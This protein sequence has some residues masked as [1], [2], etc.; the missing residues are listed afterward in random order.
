[1]P[2]PASPD[3]P[4]LY[5]VST[6]AGFLRRATEMT[7]R[8]IPPRFR[9]ATA[10]HPDVFAWCEEFSPAS[11]SLLILGPTG[12]GKTHQAFGAIRTLAARG[13]TPGWH[14]STAPGLFAGLRPREGTDA[15]GEYRKIADV[16]LL[17]LDDLGAAKGSEWTEEILYRL[18]NDR[19]E[20]ML[21]GLF[22][23]NVPAP[24]LRD[25]LG[26]RVASRLAEMCQQVALRGPDRRRAQ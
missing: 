13:V 6:R 15:E 24:Q 16:P 4:P 22:T 21:P 7:D 12:T 17:L 25:V 18:V 26:A 5:D 19:Y 20:A 8:R 10:S 1:M 11:S 14:A 3:E 9:D 23:S 2:D